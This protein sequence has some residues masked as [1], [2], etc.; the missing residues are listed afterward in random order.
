MPADCSRLAEAISATMSVTFFTAVDL[1]ERLARFVDQLAALLDPRDAVA[2]Q[3]LD[4]LGGR[5][6]APGEVAHLGGHHRKAAALLAGARGFDRGVQRQQIGLE[7]DLVDDADDVGD[8]LRG[9][10]DAGHRGDRGADHRAAL[11]RL[12]ARRHGQLVGLAG[13][14]GRL[15]DRGGHL[16]HRRGGLL[17]ARRLVLGA[18]AQLDIAA[19]IFLAP[20]R[21]SCEVLVKPVMT[22]IMD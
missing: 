20:S 10:V 22:S 12:L 3:R 11:L 1:L 8:L 5:G 2:D 16:L 15:P 4:L 14:V 9:G 19:S 13:I 18:V 17:Q 7:R 6:A 21:T